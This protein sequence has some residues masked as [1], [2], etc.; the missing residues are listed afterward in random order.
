MA[1]FDV[2]FLWYNANSHKSFEHGVRYVGTE[3]TRP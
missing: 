2:E 1:F 3:V